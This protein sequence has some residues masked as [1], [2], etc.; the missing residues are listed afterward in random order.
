MFLPGGSAH[1]E[2]VLWDGVNSV[3][4]HLSKDPT[5]LQHSGGVEEA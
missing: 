5:I 4:R 2:G 1:A 3:V